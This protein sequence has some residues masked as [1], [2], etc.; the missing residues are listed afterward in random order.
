MKTNSMV[1]LRQAAYTYEGDSHFYL[2]EDPAEANNEYI[3]F[4]GQGSAFAKSYKGWRLQFGIQL[5]LFT[6]SIE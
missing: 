6:M 4:V 1:S 5:D 2:P 3:Y